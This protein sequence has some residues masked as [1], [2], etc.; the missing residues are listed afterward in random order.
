MPA[1]P[2][3]APQ[4]FRP[5]DWAGEDENDGLPDYDVQ[6]HFGGGE[7]DAGGDLFRLKPRSA[8]DEQGEEQDDGGAAAAP[9]PRK[10]KAEVMQEVIA[11]SKAFR[12]AK[13]QQREEDIQETETLD[14]VFRELGS[15][16]AL[17]G[18]VRPKNAKM[19]VAPACGLLPA[20]LAGHVGAGRHV[21]G[22]GPAWVAAPAF[23]AQ[24]PGAEQALTRAPPG[25]HATTTRMHAR[26]QTLPALRST[27]PPRV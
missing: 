24:G 11:K 17:A 18:F 5:Q 3:A 1:H 2:S 19:C 16:G 15:A 10:T 25:A 22:W 14:K 20:R 7:D 13:Q 26:S 23:A 21:L 8:G 6:A 4:S 27:G 12:A 9:E